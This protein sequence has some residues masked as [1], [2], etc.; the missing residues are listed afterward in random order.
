[1]ES[2]QFNWFAGRKRRKKMMERGRIASQFTSLITP[3]A[4]YLG[5]GCLACLEHA[6]TSSSHRPRTMCTVPVLSPMEQLVT[7]HSTSSHTHEHS[8]DCTL[9][10]EQNKSLP[11]LSFIILFLYY[12]AL[13]TLLVIRQFY[14]FLSECSAWLC[15]LGSGNTLISQ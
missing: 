1:M 5:C 8:P 11:A 2:L 14:N 15:M 10:N 6:V 3:F 12:L 4:A 13:H 7:Q 9:W